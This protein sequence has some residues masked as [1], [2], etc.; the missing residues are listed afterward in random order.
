MGNNTLKPKA[1]NTLKKMM[2]LGIMLA[3]AQLSMAAHP[4]HTSPLSQ[5]ISKQV[6]Y[7]EFAKKSHTEAV[8]EVRYLVQPD[9]Q[10]KVISAISSNEEFETYVKE[11]LE[12]IQIKEAQE[13][14]V[15]GA[16]FVFE[17]RGR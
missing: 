15:Y 8:V 12:S 11:K 4:A 5:A 16:R 14:G 1:M 7:P 9:G 10:V 2:T 17:Y 6:T 3:M 13:P